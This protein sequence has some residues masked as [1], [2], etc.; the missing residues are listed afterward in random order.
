MQS[1][2]KR[3]SLQ[4][5]M[6]ESLERIFSDMSASIIN[7]N[8]KSLSTASAD[9]V[10]VGDSWLSFAIKQGLIEPIHGAEDQDWFKGL[11]DKWKVEWMWLTSWSIEYLCRYDSYEV[12]HVKQ[13]L[14]FTLIHMQACSPN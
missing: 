11:S 4:F 6:L 8:V 7:G 14:T 1:Q 5:K 13:L 3:S 2:G 9:L 10:T 12:I